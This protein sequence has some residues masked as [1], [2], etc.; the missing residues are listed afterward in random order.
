MKIKYYINLAKKKNNLTSD[1]QLAKIIGIHPNSLCNIKNKKSI[2]SEENFI[3]ILELAKI[4]NDEFKFLMFE[5]MAE[6][7]PNSEFSK[8]LREEMKNLPYYQKTIKKT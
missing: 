4:D 3:K 6:Y 7:R 2:P 8:Q 1:A 5:R